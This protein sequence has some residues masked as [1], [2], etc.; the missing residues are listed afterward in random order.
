MSKRAHLKKLAGPHKI[1]NWLST[2][3]AGAVK[4]PLWC[5]IWDNNERLVRGPVIFNMQF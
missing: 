4:E 2:D 5:I 1:N 3:T